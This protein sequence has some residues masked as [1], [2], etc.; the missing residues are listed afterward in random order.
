MVIIDPG[1]I[2]ATVSIRIFDDDLLEQT[3]I[4]NVYIEVGANDTDYVSVRPP[5]L[6]QVS[7]LSEDCKLYLYYIVYSCTI[8]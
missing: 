6:S 4:F 1:E 8:I 7:I 3:E 2:T 5:G